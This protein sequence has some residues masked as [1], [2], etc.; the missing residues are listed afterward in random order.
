MNP[1]GPTASARL[2]ALL[3]FAQLLGRGVER[4]GALG[5]PLLQ[6]FVEK[7]ELAGLAVQLGEDADLGA[8]QFRHHRHGQIIHRA[9]LI[10]AQIIVL[11]HMDGRDEDDRRLLEARMLADHLGQLEAVQF[12]HADIDQDHRH[13]CLSR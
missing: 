2:L 13:V 1:Y 9:G 7:M 12:G 5:D 3:A 4:L 6:F 11:R 10:A 8:Q